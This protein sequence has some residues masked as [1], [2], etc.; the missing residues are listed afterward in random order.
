VERLECYLGDVVGDVEALDLGGQGV[1]PPCRGDGSVVGG[2]EGSSSCRACAGLAGV[3]PNW[4][5]EVAMNSRSRNPR[6]ALDLLALYRAASDLG[7][8]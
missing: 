2:E 4:A 7:G 5:C 1:A 6:A 3:E 8:G